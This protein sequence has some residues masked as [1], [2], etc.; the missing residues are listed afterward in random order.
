M[1]KPQPL[2][3]YHFNQFRARI[4]HIRCKNRN[5]LENIKPKPYQ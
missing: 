2:N 5:E 3:S 1:I 4:T